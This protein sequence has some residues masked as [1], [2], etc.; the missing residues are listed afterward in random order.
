MTGVTW[1][2]SRHK[3]KAQIMVARKRLTLGYYDDAK[4][5]ASEYD[6][7]GKVGGD[8]RQTIMVG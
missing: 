2:K 7:A 1:D 3:W 4:V 8:N 6:K 5:A